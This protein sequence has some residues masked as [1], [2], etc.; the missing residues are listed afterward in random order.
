MFVW[1]CPTGSQTEQ[2]NYPK[3]VTILKMSVLGGYHI[4]V[5]HYI[6]LHIIIKAELFIC[7]CHVCR[8][9][10]RIV[11]NDIRLDAVLF[12]SPKPFFST[13]GCTYPDSKKHE[14]FG[15]AK[16]RA[17]RCCC[18]LPATNIIGCVSKWGTP[19]FTGQPW[20]SLWKS[21]FWGYTV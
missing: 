18:C 16:T 9:S 21:P 12:H 4:Y 10:D 3:G 1:F 2:G 20:L 8:L 19:Q 17:G 7:V 13:K 14:L 6:V 11:A 5:Y 15:C